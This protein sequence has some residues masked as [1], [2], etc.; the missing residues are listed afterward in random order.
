MGNSYDDHDSDDQSLVDSDNDFPN[1]SAEI[2]EI[3]NHMSSREEQ[4]YDFF[5]QMFEMKT[6]P[7]SLI[8]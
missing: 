8:A 7:E 4:T 5:F 6:E 1:V 2:A 3:S